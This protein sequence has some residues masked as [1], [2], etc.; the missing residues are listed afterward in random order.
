MKP[1]TLTR[2]PAPPGVTFAGELVFGVFERR[3]NRFL[4]RVRVR[5]VPVAAHVPNTGRMQEL[6]VEGAEVALEPKEQEAR[7]CPYDLVL[8]RGNGT[9]VCVDSRRAND[10]FE[11]VL[12]SMRGPDPLPLDGQTP[13]LLRRAP[14]YRREVSFGRRRFDFELNPGGEAAL[15]EVKSVNLVEGGAALFPD[16][17]TERGAHH[18]ELMAELSRKGRPC[19][20]AFVVM[21]ADAERFEPNAAVDPRFA[22][23]L[24]EARA[25][26]VE[27]FA[28]G[29]EASP[30]G[31]FARRILPVA[32]SW[33]ERG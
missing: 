16:A 18:L 26:G 12:R 7:K 1:S 8:V 2:R 6:L 29:C 33:D 20:V 28:L 10:V 21:R 9:W 4:A 27:V 11:A 5:G 13:P 24:R 30:L 31:L 14:G 23:A 3:V 15:V 25:A 32:L 19:M 22:C 17:P